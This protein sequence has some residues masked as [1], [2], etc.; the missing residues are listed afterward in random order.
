M[1]T[2]IKTKQDIRSQ[3]ETTLKREGP[4][5]G[6]GPLVVATAVKHANAVFKQETETRCSRKM[7][8][9][10]SRI[11][12]K[13]DENTQG[14]GRESSKSTQIVKSVHIHF[15]HAKPSSTRTVVIRTVATESIGKYSNSQPKDHQ[16][17]GVSCFRISTTAS[18]DV[19][20]PVHQCRAVTV[21]AGVEA[22]AV[23]PLGASLD[24]G[25][26]S[27]LAKENLGGMDQNEVVV[28]QQAETDEALQIRIS[29]QPFFFLVVGQFQSRP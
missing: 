23:V 27:T 12:D 18:S 26:L 2:K 6:W 10:I 5:L 8:K 25:D 19:W 1:F 20:L 7:K 28:A 29:Q 15:L 21:Y 13:H 17:A 9:E 11:R 14:K 3:G 4:K 24:A 22:S 16:K